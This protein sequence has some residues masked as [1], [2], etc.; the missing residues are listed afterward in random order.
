MRS[1]GRW[2]RRWRR[3]CRELYAAAWSQQG[4]VEIIP[5]TIAGEAWESPVKSGTGRR[6]LQDHDS[7]GER[8]GVGQLE[9]PRIDPFR[10]QAPALAEDDR[11]QHEPVE[12]DQVLLHQRIEE[13]G[14]AGQQEVFTGHLLQLADFLRHVSVDQ[15]RSRP[16]D[17]VEGG[18]DDVL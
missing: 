15:L 13:L 2:R 3:R 8:L 9:S 12:V 11:V 4:T 6:E 1:K 7:G 16:V 14:A 18:R 5:Q 10:K 17:L